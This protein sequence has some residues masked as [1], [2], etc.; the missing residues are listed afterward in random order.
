MSL[1]RRAEDRNHSRSPEEQAAGFLARVFYAAPDSLIQMR[2]GTERLPVD[3]SRQIT[4][5]HILNLL[6]QRNTISAPPY[7]KIYEN[8]GTEHTNPASATHALSRIVD[9][10]REESFDLNK[11]PDMQ[12]FLEIHLFD[13]AM[14]SCRNHGCVDCTAFI[15]EVAPSLAKFIHRTND[16]EMDLAD[17]SQ[18]NPTYLTVLQNRLISFLQTKGVTEA[19]AR[20][21]SCFWSH[22]IMHCLCSK[23]WRRDDRKEPDKYLL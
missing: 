10:E 23:R 22:G 1:E 5:G 2:E 6:V 9:E 12:Q 17:G 8:L 7:T 18:I 15:T 3:A 16:P 21:L 19:D 4:V 11:L 20:R 14:E 13:Q